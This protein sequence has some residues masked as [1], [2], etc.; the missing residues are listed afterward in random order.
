MPRGPHL[1]DFERGQILAYRDQ[2]LNHSDIARKIDRDRSV[3]SMFLRDHENYGKKR[4]PG[5]KPK[6]T[7]RDVR[8]ILRD[9]N[10]GNMTANQI[11]AKNNLPISKRRVQ[12]IISSSENLE[13]KKRKHRN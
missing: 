11:R 13:Y 6:V 7:K 2:N 8:H 3:V 5:R 1:T 9:A 12:Q 10:G 4:S